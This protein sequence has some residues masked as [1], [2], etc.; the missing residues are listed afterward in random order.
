MSVVATVWTSLQATVWTQSENSLTEPFNMVLSYLA[1]SLSS[2][3][4]IQE[5]YYQ[6]N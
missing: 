2:A 6:N 1:L 4:L 5:K 3:F